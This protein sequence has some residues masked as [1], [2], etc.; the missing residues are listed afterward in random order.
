ML[1]ATVALLGE[2]KTTETLPKRSV[3]FEK[4]AVKELCACIAQVEDEEFCSNT[5]DS[6][7]MIEPTLTDDNGNQ[8]GKISLPQL[9]AR[10]LCI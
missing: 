9:M 10:W 7:V 3:W 5:V 8:L 2:E 6:L 4:K 1:E